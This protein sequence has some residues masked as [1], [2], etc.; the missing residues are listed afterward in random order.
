VQYQGSRDVVERV[1]GEGKRAAQL[2]HLQVRVVTE[3]PPGQL[4]HPG[5]FVDAGHDGAPV[6][7]RGEQRADAAASVEN[8]PASHVPGQ[9]QHRGSL[10][11][12][13]EEV[14]LV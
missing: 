6:P 5:A 10:V 7:Q 4:H 13:I 1:V 11:V 2:S 8:P 9:R 3:P 14:V 12:G